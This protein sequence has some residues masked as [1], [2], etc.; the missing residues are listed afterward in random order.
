MTCVE[1][2]AS[3]EA[4][5]EQLREV[6][7]WATRRLL[8]LHEPVAAAA[9][10]DTAVAVASV[11]SQVLADAMA[12]A[13]AAPPSWP[14]CRRLPPALRAAAV[15]PWWFED[16]DQEAE[17]AEQGDGGVEAA[18]AALSVA[19]SVALAFR[20]A[21]AAF[22]YATTQA[23]GAAAAAAAAAAGS[24]SDGEMEA[25]YGLKDLEARVNGA[26]EGNAEHQAAWLALPD[27][28][29][30][31]GDE[32]LGAAQAAAQEE[33]VWAW[34]H[35]WQRLLDAVAGERGVWGQERAR[36][37]AF[38]AAGTGLT[39][40]GPAA[41]SWVVDD[42][43]DQLRCRRKLVR[44][45]RPGFVL[46]GAVGD[47]AARLRHEDASAR[48][49]GSGGGGGVG[50]VAAAATQLEEAGGGEPQPAPA[51]ERVLGEEEG[52]VER[53]SSREELWKGLVK[54][55]RREGEGAAADEE[56]EEEEDD[57]EEMD[58]G[59]DEE[60]MGAATALGPQEGDGRET[61]V[62]TAGATSG[63]SPPPKALQ[64][65]PTK[66]AASAAAATP[67]RLVSLAL[68]EKRRPG[69]VSSAVPA[70][71][72]LR[73]GGKSSV[74]LAATV[75]PRVLSLQST[76]GGAGLT[77]AR[78]LSSAAAGGSSGIGGLGGSALPLAAGVKE[79]RR[80]E[81]VRPFV[82]SP[83]LFEVHKA[84]LRFTL[85]EDAVAPVPPEDPTAWCLQPFPS[86][87][88]RLDELR[89]LYLRLYQQQQTALE[90]FFADQTSLFV[91]FHSRPAAV[92]VYK[93]IRKLAPR[94]PEPHLGT[95]PTKIWG[96]MRT[97]RGTAL[98]QAWQRRELSN[99]EYLSHLNLVAGR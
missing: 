30:A 92:A 68:S 28:R 49:R 21:A 27:R 14:R 45:V 73:V 60:A 62:P 98:T 74:P 91:H 80:C 35:Q 51:V 32:R 59:I 25:V 67:S 77:L 89:A 86:T 97:A 47:E 69:S 85:Q 72:L 79:A 6:L 42:V 55:R 84:A 96:R 36:L 87:L 56:E 9:A 5:E 24:S 94:G 93:A 40:V 75:S 38:G 33:R 44:R 53:S 50:V 65:S 83:G 2:M 16:E 43:E 37:R 70:G 81:V 13:D 34:H 63:A 26:L 22:V 88:W 82:V 7:F 4:Q 64:A 46:P 66:A 11:A 99:F 78:L 17:G 23:A 8:L 76:A 58:E 31:C 57:D 18:M 90:F 95:A 19:D 48:M 52:R 3:E 15:P 61:P 1:S 29:R 71:L 39:A 12:G 54:Y 41:V 20:P 10:G